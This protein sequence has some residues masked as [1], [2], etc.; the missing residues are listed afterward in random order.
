MAFSLERS[1][2]SFSAMASAVEFQIARQHIRLEQARAADALPGNVEALDVA[3]P[4]EQAQRAA[5]GHGVLRAD[6]VGDVVN[7]GLDLVRIVRPVQQ[8]LINIAD[9]SRRSDCCHR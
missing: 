2:L 4:S 8:R 1:R 7:A 9:A 3:L 6:A 5:H